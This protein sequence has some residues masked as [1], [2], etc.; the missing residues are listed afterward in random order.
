MSKTLG[1]QLPIAKDDSDGF[2]MIYTIAQM[3]RQNLKMLLLTNP[4]ERI[5]EPN[6][7]VGMATFLFESFNEG[8]ASK[9]DSKIRS[10]VAIYMPNVNIVSIKFGESK[11]S[12]ML[13]LII[14]YNIDNLGMSDSITITI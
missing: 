10:Q 8:T 1:V 13:G 6:F 5:M 14:E 9:I 12:G 2:A 4:G 3:Y 11:D 7:G